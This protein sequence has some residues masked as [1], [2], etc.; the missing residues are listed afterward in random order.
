MASEN[1]WGYYREELN[2]DVNELNDDSY[3]LN[4]EKTA[5]N[6]YF[7]YKTKI[8][9]STPIINSTLDTK[10]VVL[11]KYLSIFWKPYD[12]LLIDCEMELNL[13]WQQ[14]CVISE[15]FNTPEIDANPASVPPIT[16]ASA[17]T[18]IRSLFQ[19]NRTKR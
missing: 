18:T 16:H 14:T 11:L 13:S 6:K 15:I 4:N 8:M 2:D 12:L 7:E 1:L 5:T 19:I 10:V 3:R 17:K 9:G